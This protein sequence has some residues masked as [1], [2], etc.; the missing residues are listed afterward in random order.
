M[1]NPHLAF[2]RRFPQFWVGLVLSSLIVYISIS[3]NANAQESG[4]KRDFTFFLLSDTHVGAENLK[5]KPAVTREDTLTKLKTNLD[6]MRSLVGR[7]YPKNPNSVEENPGI[8]APPLS[9]F[10]LGDLTDGN[11]DLKQ[12]QEQRKSFN[13]LFPASGLMF[14]SNGIPIYAIAGNH[15]GNPAGPVRQGLVERNRQQYTAGRLAAISSNG[16]H[17]AIHNDG[18]HLVCMNLCPA[19]STDAIK[20]FKF[21][22][23]GPGSWNDPEGAFSFLKNYLSRHVGSSGEPVILMHHYGFDAF[24]IND[25]NWWTPA[26]RRALYD[27]LAPYNI[28]AIFHG[29]DHHA[30]HYQWPNPARHADDIDLM[31]PDGTPTSLRQ[32][33]IISCGAVCWVIRI[34]EHTLVAAHYRGPDWSRGASGNFELS[35]SPTNLFLA[36]NAIAYRDPKLPIQ[37][38]VKDLIN[39]MNLDEKIEQLYQKDAAQIAMQGDNADLSSL[40]K[41]FGDRSPGTLCVRFGDDIFQSARRLAAGQR[42]LLEKTRHGIPALTVNEGLHGVLAQGA[43]IYPQFLALGCTWNPSMAEKMGSQISAEASA[44]GINHLLTPMIEVIRDPRWGRVEEC[45]GESPFLVGQMCTAYT[46]GIQG[47]L[48]GKP[49]AANKTLAM[50]KT[51]AGYSMPVNGINIANCVL[52]ERELRSIYFPPVEQ[53]IRETG[54]LSVMPSY[55]EIDGIP[56]HANRWLLEDILR[57]EMGFRGYTYSDWGGVE[58]NHSFHRV[59]SDRAEAA[60]IAL[61]AGVDLEAPGPACFQYLPQLVRE[62]RISG[63]EID[64]AAS[65]V[66]YTKLAAGLFDGR[67]NADFATLAGITRCADHVALSQQIAEES[68]VLL[69]NDNNLLPL[70]PARLKSI[71]VIGPNADQVQFGD[72]CWSKSNKDG[73]TLLRGLRERLD[74]QVQIHYSK[75]CDLAGRS[76]NGFAAAI[77]A[78]QK[79]DVAV[80][81]LGDT[82]MILSG[83]G[84]EDKSL[85]AS[86][87]VG[88]GY[89]VT[90]PVPPGVQQDLVREVLKTGK[91]VI[92]VFI[93]GRPYSVPWMKAKVPAIVEAFYPGQQQGYA[94]ADILLGRVN[95][96]GR[97]SMT[98]PQS[99]GHIP[100]VHDYKPSGRGFYHSPGSEDKLGRDYVFA[101]PAPLWAFGFGL[102][103]TKFDYS[104]LKIETPTIPP[105]GVVRLNFSLKNSGSRPGKEVAQVY[106]RDD[107]SSVTTPTMK[108]VGFAKVNLKPGESRRISITIPSV[109][110]ALWNRQMKRV[111]EPGIFTVMIGS[112]SED[113][114]LRGSFLVNKPR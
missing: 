14:G 24:S 33:D 12:Q 30:D 111:V 40:Q 34:K 99:A 42:Y 21:G 58:F 114:S 11:D 91:P 90:D 26:Q 31:F 72:Y 4:L 41:L 98:I 50:L 55:N 79:S 3:C 25:W 96:S 49:L 2:C 108:L 89:D 77:E 62:G 66:L 73:I 17:F 39:R 113:V 28:A 27:L 23:Q 78:A 15:D 103:Y 95:P 19:D 46:L 51:F 56:S 87:T 102:S 64:K 65:R 112:S 35:L 105:D 53:V 6:L 94:I 85:P 67:A 54:V 70:D 69:K 106:L 60:E 45:I 59:A 1:K 80:V 61:K 97:L 110:L 38:R 36:T 52:G 75:G 83:V 10:I 7:P 88:E 16:V 18:V 43:T 81:V 8:V 101:S 37:Q 29:H 9:L 104:E 93:N 48:R 71:A 92:V 84:W 86:G 44:A 32:F 47:N 100:T 107:V 57:G 68:I 109:E 5:A 20:P 22:K 82:S 76:T 13:D 63:S 74:N